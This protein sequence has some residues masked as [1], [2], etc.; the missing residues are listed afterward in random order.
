MLLPLQ[1]ADTRRPPARRSRPRS[2]L[3][4]CSQAMVDPSVPV[5]DLLDS[6]FASRY[7]TEPIA[8]DKCAGWLAD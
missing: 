1:R 3:P 6:T 5:G 7:V 8:K 2:L 4:R